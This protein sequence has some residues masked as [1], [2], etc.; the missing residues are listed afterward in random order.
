[1]PTYY[2]H[3]DAFNLKEANTKAEYESLLARVQSLEKA[4]KNKSGNGSKLLY[5]NQNGFDIYNSYGGTGTAHYATRGG[6]EA[7]IDEGFNTVTIKGTSQFEQLNYVSGD[8]DTAYWGLN[9][10]ALADSDH[11]NIVQFY[12]D[13]D[14]NGNYTI[15]KPANRVWQFTIPK[16]PNYQ[17]GDTS[18][19]WIG[20]CLWF[21][22]SVNNN[23]AVNGTPDLE[24][25]TAASNI[26]LS[27]FGSYRHFFMGY[28]SCFKKFTKNGHVWLVPGKVR[29]V[30]QHLEVTAIDMKDIL[31]TL[32]EQGGWNNEH[33]TAAGL[34]ISYE[35]TLNIDR[36]GDIV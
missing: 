17:E 25:E 23:P 16:T 35:V 34:Q 15:D 9:L 26:R 30:G 4:L 5:V 31:S 29:P 10:D 7:I 8:E 21:D 14:S 20:K 28:H 24:H 22:N 6:A 27:N 2:V 12:K 1:M 19:V 36:K 18:Q 3:D 32:K 13:K 11:L 33:S